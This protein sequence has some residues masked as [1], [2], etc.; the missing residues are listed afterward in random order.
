MTELQKTVVVAR[1]DQ[2]TDPQ[3]YARLWLAARNAPITRR[4]WLDAIAD[5]VRDFDGQIVYAPGIPY[6]IP[7][8][9]EIFGDDPEMRWLGH[10]LTAGDPDGT[11]PLR[12]CTK[13]ERLRLMDLYFRI[14]HPEIAKH[15]EL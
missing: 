15:F 11:T 6:R 5:A 3:Y 13:L 7:C 14:R 4:D 9:D 8:V 10:Y 1:D 12:R 2:L